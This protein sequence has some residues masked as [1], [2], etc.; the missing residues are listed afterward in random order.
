[1]YVDSTACVGHTNIQ[2]PHYNNDPVF[3]GEMSIVIRAC[4]FSG[5]TDWYISIF[6]LFC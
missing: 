1:M 2:V 5:D 3:Q 6:V 4:Y